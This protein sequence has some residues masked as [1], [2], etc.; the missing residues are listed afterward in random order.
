MLLL[1]PYGSI[2]VDH[3]PQGSGRSDWSRQILASTPWKLEGHTI[4]KYDTVPPRVTYEV[5]LVFDVY[6]PMVWS[7][8]A[9]MSTLP[10]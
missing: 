7:D 10:E 5:E 1:L 8:A 3:D 6:R 9:E 4:G 2:L